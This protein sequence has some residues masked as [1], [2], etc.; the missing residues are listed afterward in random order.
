MGM[1]EIIKVT[2]KC[3]GCKKCLPVCPVSIITMDGKMA[4]IGEGCI[5]C[6]ACEDICPV[7][8]IVINREANKKEGL[9]DVSDFKHILVYAE[10]AGDSIM[11]VGIEL[12]SEAKLLA[13]D[14]ECEVWAV[15]IGSGVKKLADECIAYGADKV[16]VIDNELFKEYTND[17]Y[18]KAIVKLIN[19]TKP[20]IVLMG[21]TAVGRSLAARIAV[22]IQTGLT[23]DCTH[24]GV[25]MDKKILLQTRPAF[26]GNIMATIAC[27]H[28]RPQM[29]TVRPKVMKLGE[30]DDARKGEIIDFG[31]D[32]KKDEIRTKVLEVLRS[33][34]EKVN[35]A[36]A[37]IIISGGRGLKK[38]ENF[39]ML[40]QLADLLGGAVGASRAV[41]DAE[42]IESYHQVGQTGK[43]VQ[44]KIYFAVGIS[45]AVQ[46][47]AGMSSSDTIIAINSDPNAPIFNIA[48]YGIV[49]DL[50]EVVPAIIK[51]I[52]KEKGIKA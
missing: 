5:V 3:I 19:E 22:R 27:E 9:P 31:V 38:P 39:E 45:G 8:A 1:D 21:A 25:D 10:T 52:K 44:P 23:A 43:T 17:A 28:Y 18:T 32:I 26:G 30:K 33:G 11:S 46:H 49:G 16:F 13:K 14:L 37:E 34:E 24:L 15:L 42:W 7:N 4:K 41:V 36:D 47:V 35:L 51:E 40:Y 12:I 6:G 20:E 50:F 48:T 29:A 2:S